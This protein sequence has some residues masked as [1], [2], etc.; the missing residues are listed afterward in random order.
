LL[1]SADDPQSARIA[2]LLAALS[3]LQ[4]LH[5]LRLE[6][7]MPLRLRAV[8]SLM[9]LAQL[10]H[11]LRELDLHGSFSNM[12]QLGIELRALHWLHRLHIELSDHCHGQADRV[13]LF[14]SLLAD[15]PAAEQSPFPVLQRRNFSFHGFVFTDRWTPLLLRLPLL[16]RLAVDLA[17]C[18]HFDFLTAL[19]RLTEMELHLWHMEDDAW[20]KLID[21]FTSDSLAHLHA[22]VLRSG[23]CSDDDLFRLLFHTPTLTRLVLDELDQVSSL[24]FFRQLPKLA[25]TLTDL[26]VSCRYTQADVLASDLQ[27]LLFLQQLRVLRLLDWSELSAA[28]RTPFE[29]RPCAVCCLS[30]RCLNGR[31]CRIPPACLCA[32]VE[33]HCGLSLSPASLFAAASFPLWSPSS[34]RA[35]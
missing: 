26:T 8:A 24:S 9:G 27:S 22:L 17:P 1:L 20:A 7:R 25:E 31:T 21:V 12:Q 2:V 30:W 14:T 23:P 3:P 34:G 16:E 6:F 18:T 32:A 19:Q 35:D 10:Q 5:T 28:D 11:T 4:Q 13:L 29:Q 15:A 33:W